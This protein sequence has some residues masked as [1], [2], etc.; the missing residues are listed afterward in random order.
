M[1]PKIWKMGRALIR[2]LSFGKS[3]KALCIILLKKIA[4]RELLIKKTYEP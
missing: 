3:I 1:F 4:K 2:V